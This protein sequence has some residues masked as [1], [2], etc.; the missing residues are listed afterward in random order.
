MGLTKVKLLGELGRRFG[1]EW[2]LD[3]Q[4]PVEALRAI[5]VQARGFFEFLEQSTKN[6]VDYRLVSGNPLGIGEDQLDW[7]LSGDCLVIAPIIRAKGGIG[8]VLLG[9]VLV[10]VALA[11]PAS[12]LGLSSMTTIGLVGG[13]LILSGLSQMLSPKPKSSKSERDDSFIV[14]RAAQTGNQGQAVPLLIGGDL[15]FEPVA[16]LSSSLSVNEY[17]IL[18]PAPIA[19]P[20]PPP[21]VDTGEDQQTYSDW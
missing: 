5:G 21:D 15:Y 17:S 13:S 20:Q 8:R 1:R 12:A 16:V 14:D 10:G 9:V 6:G 4:T 2:V 11:V 3:I 7:Y 18:P 19:P